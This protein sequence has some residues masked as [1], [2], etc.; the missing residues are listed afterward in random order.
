[1]EL[2]G[3][4][5]CQRSVLHQFTGLGATSPIPGGLVGLARPIV[6]LP[7]V[8]LDLA[9]DGRWRSPEFH[10]NRT[11]R[12]ACYHRSRDFF[13]LGQ[14]QRQSGAASSCRMYPARLC[15]N[16]LYR[17]V[18]PI[19]QLGDLLERLTFPPA[20]PHQRFL[21]FRVIDPRSLLHLQHSFCLRSILVCCIHRLNPQ[22]TSGHSKWSSRMA[23]MG[24]FETTKDN[25]YEHDVDH[26]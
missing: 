16:P 2:V 13:P 14:C 5:V 9:A 1:M 19:K 15:Q 21:A 11:D 12:V 25:R 26:H 8:A 20:L 18:V 10:S 24:R 22:S 17:G 6:F 7:T 4:E 23:G 3:H